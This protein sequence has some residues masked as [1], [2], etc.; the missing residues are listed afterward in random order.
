M[1]QEDTPYGLYAVGRASA[2]SR[3]MGL[4]E[5]RFELSARGTSLRREV[6]AG[7]T[8]FA[9]LSYI[10]FV[11]PVL[12]GSTGM[13][14]SGVYFATCVASGIACLA[15]G[16]MAN[17]PIA[18]APAMGH[19]VFF[20]FAVCGAAGVG[21]GWPWQQ[22]LAANLIAGLALLALTPTGLRAAVLRAVPPQLAAGITAGI[23][24]LIALLGMQWSGLV[25]DDP[26]T[27]VSLGALDAPATLLALFGLTVTCVLF[28]RRV[29]GAVL[30][31][32]IVTAAAGI[33]VSRLTDHDLV[34]LSGVVSAPP[35]P[36][37]AFA[38]D[39]SGLLARPAGEWLGVVLMFL[40]LDLFDT[41]GTLLGVGRHARLLDEE[42]RLPRAAQAL[43]ADAIGTT[44]G[45]ALGTSTVTSYV[46]SAAGVAVGGRTG[47]VAIV[48]GLAF[49][50]ALF[51]EPLVSVFGAPL[52]LE[53]GATLYPIL[54]PT[55]ILVGGSMVGALRDVDWEDPSLAI[56]AF[57][58]ALIIPLGFSIAAGIAWGCVATSALDLARGEPR[59]HSPV[60]HI[61]SVG[62]LVHL[63][64]A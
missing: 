2:K 38:L 13:E 28:A 49:F 36:S 8:T 50:G 46:E 34:Q 30:I 61:V 24:L 14:P 1:P 37:A 18:L 44:V 12:L 45:A 22:A 35:E 48:V 19:N 32:I 41:V 62:V 42:G 53:S 52:V 60:L 51:L 40:F 56:P 27:L 43:G 54:A 17:Q 58:T 26:V 4:L 3:A 64:V 57:L 9:T 29:P 5:R 6:V 15:M 23:G 16:L 47:L 55:L 10:L 59:R 33:V 11:Q 39:F 20:A 31:G 7:L 25:V 21:A 63:V